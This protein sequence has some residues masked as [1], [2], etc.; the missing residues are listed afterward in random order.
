[1][2][3]SEE[4]RDVVGDAI[5]AVTLNQEVAWDRCARIATPR[6][7]RGLD[8]LR[9]LAHFFPHS[10]TAGYSS[11]STSAS[12]GGA[13]A[14]VFMRNAA[15]AVL[16][17]ATVQV[18]ATL[19]LL[20]W[21]WDAYHRD[22]GE[23][24]VYVLTLFLG[25]AASACLLLL[26]GRRDPRT[27]LLGA[28][29]L[30]KATLPPMHMLP[31][32]WWGMPLANALEDSL[33]EL[34]PQST[35]FLYLY[36]YPF[37]FA[38]AFLWAFARECPRIH[39][40]TRLDDFARRM[41][42]VCM[43][44][45]FALWGGLVLLHLT[46]AATP[47]G[48]LTVLGLLN[49]TPNAMSLGAV[50]VVT[51]RAR[52]A[53]PAEKR[54]VV[55]FSLGFLLWMGWVTAYDVAEAFSSG[56]WGANYRPTAFLTLLQLVRFPG[57]VL[58]WYAVLASRVPHP[59]EVIRAGCRWLL[60]RP[61]LLGA[62]AAAPMVGL[63]WLLAGNPE[64]E[65]G[66]VVADPLARSLFAVAVLM[67][68]V[69]VARERLLLRLEPWFYPESADQREV[70]AVAT[71]ALARAERVATVGR[72]ATRAA[73][74]GCGS[75]ATL[76]VVAGEQPDVQD[77]RAPDA[78]IA[79]LPRTSAIN[80]VLETA[81]RSVRVHPSDV[82]SVFELLPPEEA[83]WVVRAAADVIVPVPG[84]GTQVVGILVVG[85]RFDD[86]LV[87]PVDVAFLEVLASAAGQAVARLRLLHGPGAGAAEAPAARECPACRYLAGADEP[88]ECDCGTRYVDAEV[89]RL[90]A[91]KYRLTRR[92]GAGGMG[93]V[94]LARDI[95]L[96]R[97]VAVKTLVG[98]SLPRSMALK[99]EAST[100]AQVAHP[101]VAQVHGV[102][103]W[104]GHPF[105]VVEF[106]AGGT[107]ADR[108]R[109]GPIPAPEA[110]AVTVQL[111]E[112]LAALHR[113]GYLH[114]D[115]KPS[116]IGFTAEG[117][118][119]LLDFG[120]ARPPENAAVA[121]GTMRYLSPEVLSGRPAGDAD[122]VWSLCVVLY[123]MA[124]GNHP[125]AGEN[126]EE[127]ADR[128]RRQH[129]GAGA[130]RATAGPAAGTC[131]TAFA[132]SMLVAA[133]SARPATARAFADALRGAMNR[134][135]GPELPGC[136]PT[137]RDPSM[138]C[139]LQSRRRRLP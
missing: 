52:A 59:L 129:A 20:P 28:Y 130:G 134:H 116:N 100:M 41:V 68:L 23:L 90:L 25:H 103:S 6:E 110:V 51:L 86:R 36:A 133:R 62:V 2:P 11:A 71:A 102:E 123:E 61:G 136:S 49:V 27:A 96:D 93:S 137:I 64:Q 39:R 4:P 17:I 24:A 35:L 8:N 94:Y 22:H 80:Y 82:K 40:R 120:L 122:D 44:V 69:A 79:P 125:F 65:V 56:S 101:A 67:L 21:E 117:A 55:L 10:R 46:W 43:V 88:P 83:A 29:F 95:G 47:S 34:P 37:G 76:L 128:I 131:V 7:R 121:G 72:I 85:R 3:G 89:P 105:L 54:R 42:A 84:P 99:P 1:M 26:A 138:R 118:P 33:W 74:R 50:A 111:A 18:A 132:A 77:F 14:G 135:Q 32:F 73:R 9:S 107:L 19:L 104:R 98:S 30:L 92:L 45:G 81:G 91:G 12:L 87:R 106:L 108:L 113:A 60:V 114:G 119:K 70:L 66:A 126:V 115:V 53:P 38:P 63:G 139:S 124:S 57:M 109:E 13:F 31:A 15:R 5:D 112:A 48:F 78:R 97:D 75:A 127:V 58:L 16:A